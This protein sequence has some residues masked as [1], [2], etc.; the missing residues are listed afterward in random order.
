MRVLI[1]R[2]AQ[3]SVTVE[4]EMVGS[5]DGGYLLLVGITHVD[6]RETVAAMTAKVVNLRLFEDENG[7]INHSLLDLLASDPANAGILVVS[8]FTLY[9]RTKK[10]RRPSFIEAARPEAARPLIGFFCDQLRS[11]D[12]HVETG[13]FGAHMRVSLVNDGPVT[14]WLDSESA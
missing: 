13:V 3:A 1:Q 10:G 8:Q 6:T 9:A 12:I 2:V 4:E 14:I 11:N 7:Q 5:I